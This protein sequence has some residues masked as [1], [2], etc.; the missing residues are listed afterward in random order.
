MGFPLRIWDTTQDAKDRYAL[1]QERFSGIMK[2]LRE[3]GFQCTYIGNLR[4]N[5]DI[6]PE[7]WLNSRG[8]YPHQKDTRLVLSYALQYGRSGWWNLDQLEAFSHGEGEMLEM[9]MW[10]YGFRRQKK[11]SS[12]WTRKR[13]GDILLS[14]VK[15]EAPVLSEQEKESCVPPLEN[16]PWESERTYFICAGRTG[17]PYLSL[18]VNP[19]LH[20]A[21]SLGILGRALANSGSIDSQQEGFTLHA[22]NVRVDDKRYVH[23]HTIR[24]DERELDVLW[25]SRISVQNIDSL[26]QSL[27]DLVG[28]K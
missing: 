11:D 16:V 18:D 8:F 5:K 20:N 23:L 2:E 14:E 12:Q 28:G 19:F 1:A 7:V 27:V 25:P 15:P 26:A 22:R 10:E 4:F 3:R 9:A 13:K 17:L 6:E 21:D 24:N